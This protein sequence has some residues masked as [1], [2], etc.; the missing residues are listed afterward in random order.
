MHFIRTVEYTRFGC[1]IKL[2]Q[3]GEL[4]MV[5]TPTSPRLG[6]MVAKLWQHDPYVKALHG[7]VYKTK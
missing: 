4:T 2:Y 3:S 6:R 1:L 7:G 5:H